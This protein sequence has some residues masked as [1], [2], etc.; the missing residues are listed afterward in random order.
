MLT[1]SVAGGAVAGGVAGGHLHGLG[2]L[3]V[4]LPDGG[5]GGDNVIP[6]GLVGA[7]LTV[8][9]LVGLLAHGQLLVEAVVFVNHDL[10]V[11]DDG[12]HLV[13][14]GGH[15]DLGVDGGVGVPAVVLRG[16][17]GGVVGFVGGSQGQHGA[18]YKE[19]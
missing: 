6:V 18:Q 14:K 16:V 17:A 9:D 7:D 1:V 5:A 2:L 8:D 12:G 4:S 19:G 10:D 11:Q 13:G 15:A 3:G